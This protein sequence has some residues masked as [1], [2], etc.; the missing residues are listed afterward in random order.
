M[1]DYCDFSV[2]ISKG[3]NKGL[4]FECSSFD[5]EISIHSVMLVKD[6]HTYKSKSKYERVLS[7]YNGPDFTTL[8]ERL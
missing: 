1:Q 3:D 8:D 4:V 5:S 7:E 6:L 2:Y